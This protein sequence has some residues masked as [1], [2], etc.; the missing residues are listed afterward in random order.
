MSDTDDLR[1]LRYNLV[2]QL[3]RDGITSRSV[4]RAMSHVPRERF[5]GSG[6]QSAAYVDRALPIGCD[7]TI[8]QPYIVAL[9]TQALQLS[10]SEKILEV[11]TG[12]GYQTA[13]LAQLAQHV[14]TIER[15]PE[16]SERAAHILGELGYHN[17]SLR[18]GDG[19]AGWPE[20]APFERIVV[21]AAAATVP[22]ALMDQ[23]RD[24]GILVVPVGGREG[25]VLQS[26]RKHQ[27]KAIVTELCGCRFV[28][29]V[30]SD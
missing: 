29:L 26:I 9:M 30:T 6:V 2:R 24:E 14:F 16:L 1:L 23:L 22:P 10:G 5:I 18:V 4:L 12:S 19:S 27:G 7:Q 21:T 11:G 20:E 17:V 8:S 15:W 3:Q 13:V 25:Q 28:P